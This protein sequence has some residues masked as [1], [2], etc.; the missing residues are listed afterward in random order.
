MI[1]YTTYHKRDE[2]SAYLWDVGAAGTRE[3]AMQ[4]ITCEEPDVLE[5]GPGLNP[6]YERSKK[7]D[8]SEGTDIQDTGLASSS[9]ECIAMV[10][11]LEHV[12]SDIAAM[13][14]CMRL[15]KPGGIVVVIAP[16]H[17]S[18]ICDA[19]E[20]RENGHI[21]RYSRERVMFLENTGMSC[22]YYRHIHAA[23]NMIWNRLKIIL[24]ALNYLPRKIDGIS[25][26]DRKLYRKAM[27]RMLKALDWLDRDTRGKG[28]AMFVMKKTG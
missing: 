12:E 23:H 28:N 27:P 3:A 15:L 18:M 20:I 16:A 25:L 14:E 13:Y 4:F 5:V 21:R 9:Y 11:V 10:H 22:I 17:K 7:I 6:L 2:Q 1:D 8:I 19:R 24:K 26:Y